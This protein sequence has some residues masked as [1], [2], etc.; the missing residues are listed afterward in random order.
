MLGLVKPLYSEKKIIQALVTIG[1][2]KQN[3]FNM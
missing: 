3:A 2:N 1:I